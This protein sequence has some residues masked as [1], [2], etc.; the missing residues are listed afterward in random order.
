MGDAKEEAAIKETLTNLWVSKGKVEKAPNRKEALEILKELGK[1]LESKN[2]DK[3]DD[4]AK[5]LSKY[6][7]ALKPRDFQK[8]VFTIVDKNPSVYKEFL[9]EHGMDLGDADEKKTH[10]GASNMCLPPKPVIYFAF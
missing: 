4:T 2:G 7:P 1:A 5:R 9:K 6:Y 3:F 8:V 10:E